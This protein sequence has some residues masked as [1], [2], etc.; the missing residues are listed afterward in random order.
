M[1]TIDK[2][3]EKINKVTLDATFKAQQKYGFEIGTGSHS[4]WNNEADAFKH[5]YMQWYLSYYHGLPTAKL[6][7]DFHEFETWNGPENERNMDFWNNSVGREIAQKMKKIPEFINKSPEEISDIASR[8]IYEKMQ[9]GELITSPDDMR[10]FN[11]FTGKRELAPKQQPQQNN[12]SNQNKKVENLSSSDSKYHNRIFD[13]HRIVN[14]KN[15]VY[16]K[17][18]KR[19]D[20]TIVKAHWRSYPGD[21]DPDKRLSEMQEPELSHALDFWMDILGN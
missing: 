19:N 15:E 18:Y 6:L 17:E 2:I 10:K 5:A 3:R 9:N 4:T 7:G 11:F 1:N 16:V 20:G 12:T 8:I 13:G 14:G 21:F